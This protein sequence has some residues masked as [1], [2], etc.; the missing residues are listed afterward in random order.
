MAFNTLIVTK[1]AGVATLTLNRP[2]KL[3]AWDEEMMQ[4]GVQAVEEIC[5]DLNVRVLV[6]TGAGRAFSA[7]ADVTS[8]AREAEKLKTGESSVRDELS[9]WPGIV[10]VAY[11]LRQIDRPV[12]AAINGVTAGAGF[13][14]ALAC[15]IRIASDQARFSQ[16]FVKRGL[17]PDTGSTYFLPRIVG[18]EKACELMFRGS[19]IDAYEAERLGIVSR[20]VPHGELM[21]EVMALAR[22]LANSA[23]IALGLT[24]RAIY[25]GASEIDLAAQMDLELYLDTLLF[26]TEDFRE[27]VMSF[28]EK[29]EPRFLGR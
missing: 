14:L 23:P 5:S 24:K 28:L 29:R 4:E 8:L 20:V 26:R 1:E 2:N 15:D 7:G 9:S 3:N 11:R 22:E 18:T 19:V 27:G 17:V 16:I 6:I 25:K 13:G 10:T 21:N 12:I